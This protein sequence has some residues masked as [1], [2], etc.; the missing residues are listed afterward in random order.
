I[1]AENL[2]ANPQLISKQVDTAF[3]LEMIL[4]RYLQFEEKGMLSRKMY[5]ACLF[6]LTSLV[7][8]GSARA[9]YLRENLV[10]SRRVR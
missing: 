5:D 9:Y 1:L 2:S 6:L 4:G 8:T 10:R 7:E 3:Y